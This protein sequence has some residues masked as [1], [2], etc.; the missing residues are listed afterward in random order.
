MMNEPVDGSHGHHFVWKNLIPFAERSVGGNDEAAG[1]I[2]VC[3]KLEQNVG[4]LLSLFNETQI[5]Q[6]EHPEL[7]KFLQG[8]FELELLSSLLKL[9]YQDGAGVWRTRMPF[10]VRP[11]PMAAA[12]WVLPAPLAPNSSKL[13]AW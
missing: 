2:A 1:F 13:R 3:D 11:W 4:L 5:I 8:V 6:N 9:L 12:K 7:V 10:S